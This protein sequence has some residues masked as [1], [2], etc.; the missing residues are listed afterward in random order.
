MTIQR[1]GSHRPTIKVPATP[2]VVATIKAPVHPQKGT[3][4]PPHIHVKIPKG[5]GG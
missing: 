2:R 1:S 5:P 3:R 4:N